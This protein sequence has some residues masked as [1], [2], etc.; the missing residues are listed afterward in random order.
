MSKPS[1]TRTEV[2]CLM[3]EEGSWLLREIATHV[4]KWKLPTDE[5]VK[6]LREIADEKE[7]QSL[8]I[9][10]KDHLSK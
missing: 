10:V 8:V 7:G 4:E 1:L 6:L 2:L 5:I 9:K 3:H